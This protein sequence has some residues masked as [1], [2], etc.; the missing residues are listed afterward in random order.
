MLNNMGR[1]TGFISVILSGKIQM[2]NK[3]QN[4][5]LFAWKI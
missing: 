4:N 3:I 2:L 5:R 1:N